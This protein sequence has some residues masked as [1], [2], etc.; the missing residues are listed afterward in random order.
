MMFWSRHL[1]HASGV[2]VGILG[3]GGMQALRLGRCSAVQHEVLH[4]SCMPKP[5]DISLK[6][7]MILTKIIN[8]RVVIS[9]PL[10]RPTNMTI[11]GVHMF[12]SQRPSKYCWPTPVC[13]HNMSCYGSQPLYLSAQQQV[14][15]NLMRCWQLHFWVG[16]GAG[17][18]CGT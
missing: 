14:H 10:A 6:L 12:A 5:Q 18:C 11:V 16:L 8:G 3:V 4:F 17:I 15:Q 1:Q 2:Y 7:V 13:T 9:G